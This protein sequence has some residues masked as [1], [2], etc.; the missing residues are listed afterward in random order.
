MR[1]HRQGFRANGAVGAMVA[2]QTARGSRRRVMVGVRTRFPVPKRCQNIGLARLYPL[3]DD[4]PRSCGLRRA[5]VGRAA[6]RWTAG[7]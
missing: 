2:S 5:P 3:P 6:A 4:D 1:V 7:T